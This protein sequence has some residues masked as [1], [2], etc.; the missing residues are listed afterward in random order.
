MSFVEV[1][2]R[3]YGSK[4]RFTDPLSCRHKSKFASIRPTIYPPP[5]HYNF[6]YNYFPLILRLLQCK[7]S[8]LLLLNAFSGDVKLGLNFLIYLLGLQEHVEMHNSLV[9]DNLAFLVL[10]PTVR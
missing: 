10:A 9:L 7:P 6:E 3:F 2:R 8:H 4:L 5:Q 1:Y